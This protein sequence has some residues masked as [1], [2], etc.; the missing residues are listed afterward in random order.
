MERLQFE[1]PREGQKVLE[2]LYQD[3]D[4]RIVS[5]PRGLCPV[6]MS[7]NF[8][9]LCHAQ[10]CGKCTPCRVGLGQLAKLLDA[11]LDGRAEEATVELIE[12]TAQQIMD[13]ADCAIGYEAARMVHDGVRGFRDDYLNHIAHGSCLYGVEQSIP[14]MASCPAHVDVPGYVSLVKEE[15]F[16][17][18]VA[19]IRKD[20]PFDR[21]RAAAGTWSMTR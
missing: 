12:N 18:A 13:T 19:L 21:R 20:N 7:L 14:C 3:I 5:S 17:E 6:D 4:R 16:D 2:G 10:S 15:R 8:L 11:V 9:R 1:K